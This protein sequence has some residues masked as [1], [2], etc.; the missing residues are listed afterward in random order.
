MNV[1]TYLRWPERS[2]TD[3]AFCS[4]DRL[5]LVQ[6]DYH[7]RVRFH[8]LWR[9]HDFV[10]DQVG[11]PDYYEGSSFADSDRYWQLFLAQGVCTGI[12]NGLLF[13]PCLA[14][15]STYFSKKRSLAIGI[16]ASGTAT[17][18]LIYPA[19]VQQLLHKVGFP[20]TVR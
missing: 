9:L 15:L 5:W 2:N 13:C 4:G 6:A 11:H 7:R 1:L 8:D 18:G 3:S 16:A 14:V 12:G 17:G 10:I 19:I 20:W